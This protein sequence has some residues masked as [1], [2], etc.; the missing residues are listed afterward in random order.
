MPLESLSVAKGT[1]S[2]LVSGCFVSN[3]QDEEDLFMTGWVCCW[4]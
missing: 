2:M 3:S 1:S 4:G